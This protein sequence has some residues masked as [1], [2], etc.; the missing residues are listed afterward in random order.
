[1]LGEFFGRLGSGLDPTQAPNLGS[2]YLGLIVIALAAAGW[3]RARR[4]GP[5]TALALIA[6]VMLLGPELLIA[7]HALMP[8]P[9]ALV[10]HLPLLNYLRAPSRFYALLALPLI[11]MASF[12]LL[13]IMRALSARGAPAPVAAGLVLVIVAAAVFESLFRLPHPVTQTFV[14]PVYAKLAELPGSPALLEVPGGGFNDYQWLSYQRDSRL[15]IVNDAS[16][17]RTS[18]APIPAHRNPFAIRTVGR[19]SLDLIE[20]DEEYFRVNG[21]TNPH[22]ARGVRELAD[23]GVGYAVL[24]HRTLFAWA[25]PEDPSYWRYRA[26]LERYL[27]APVFED[28]FVALYALPGAPGLGEVRGWPSPLP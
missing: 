11:V 28:A 16:P 8:L 21:R 19:P 4:T 15:P 3:S 26:F 6:G 18:D 17:R 25:G 14:P 2:A 23:L 27:G 20:S 13:R 7:G 5:W 10:E 12:G 24:H 22:R 9:Y 1:V